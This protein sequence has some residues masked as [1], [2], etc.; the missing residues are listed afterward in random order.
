MH[1]IKCHWNVRSLPSF[2]VKKIP[3]S[4][5]RFTRSIADKSG[6]LGVKCIPSWVYCENFL[7][8]KLSS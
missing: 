6:L 2:K 7:Y 8:V 3:Y 5:L 1:I 4:R